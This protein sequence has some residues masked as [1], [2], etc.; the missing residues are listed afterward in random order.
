VNVTL[1]DEREHPVDVLSSVIATLS[2]DVAFAL[3]VYEPRALPAVGAELA[4]MALAA[5]PAAEAAD[6]ERISKPLA[7]SADVSPK[8]N[9]AE[10]DDRTV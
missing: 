3:G 5:D 6:E 10:N 1:L 2:C 8:V 4:E 7:R 9:D